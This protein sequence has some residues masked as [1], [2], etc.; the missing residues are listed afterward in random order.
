MTDNESPLTLIVHVDAGSL[1][2]MMEN[3][4]ATGHRVLAVSTFEQARHEIEQ[5]PVDVVIADAHLGQFHGLHVILLARHANPTVISVVLSRRD[6]PILQ[7]EVEA[8]GGMMLVLHPPMDTV[9][10]AVTR[11]VRE[12]S[13][14]RNRNRPD[15]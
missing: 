7:R 4:R 15:R 9:V 5:R 13:A 1:K 11:R 6:D 8:A 3:L 12:V 14:D 2:A 10:A